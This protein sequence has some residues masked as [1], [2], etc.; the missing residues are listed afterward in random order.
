MNVSS[1][2]QYQ[3]PNDMNA[4][5][6]TARKGGEN[7]EYNVDITEEEFRRALNKTKKTTPGMDSIT[8][9]ILELL[10]NKIQ[11]ELL[12]IYN[13]SFGAAAAPEIW[14]T[15]L[16]LPILKPAKP[17]QEIKSY[18]PISLLSCSGKV[19]ERIIG[20]RLEY[21]AEKN[22]LLKPYQFGFRK[23]KSTIDVLTCVEH[24]IRSS[25]NAGKTCLV[26]YIDLESAFDKVW[27]RGLIYKLTK[28]NIKGRMLSWLDAYLTERTFLVEVGGKH[29]DKTPT[30]G[31]VPQG[32]AI[33]P[34]LFNLM[35]TD[36]PQTE[37]THIY[38]FADDITIISS[39]FRPEI[40]KRD[41]EAY[42]ELF[43]D[44]AEKWSIVINPG[45]TYL[46]VFGRRKYPNMPVRI[47]NHLLKQKSEQRLLG[48]ILDA[49]FLTW[50]PHVKYL[51]ANCSERN[52]LMKSITSTNWGACTKVLRA[53]YIAYIRSKLDYG[54]TLYAGAPEVNLRKLEVTQNNSLRL[55]LGARKTSPIL[56]LRAESGIP[57]LSF[58]RKFLTIKM[59]IK[60]RYQTEDSLVKGLV[61]DCA[62]G[63][64]PFN[65]F[66]YRAKLDTHSISFAITKAEP[67]TDYPII[68]P[69][70]N[71]AQIVI[72]ST[73]EQITQDEEL[74]AEI[75]NYPNFRSLFVDGSRIT[76]PCIST[77]SAVYI[78]HQNITLKYRLR[79][80]ATVFHSELYA[81]KKALD[82]IKN[83]NNNQDYI[84]FSDCKSALS[85]ICSSIN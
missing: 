64:P 84:I 41:L 45:K 38:A 3:I 39:N 43:M 51:I 40:A 57:S 58:R 53:F 23:G 59:R 76:R 50:I 16:I 81:I 31:G 22:Q 71:L 79:P 32:A 18:R 35:L 2:S 12:N 25:C 10:P 72:L 48:L 56:S 30:E 29:S 42:L 80:E 28:M 52:D 47:R 37:G 60:L 68:A 85:C 36:I 74:E 34:L 14:R 33:S 75:N 69:W 17:K 15:S 62:D 27:R 54:S 83:E 66:R 8:Y 49:P 1:L 21:V 78:P 5:I 55:M 70:I 61:G 4:A 19:L 67:F 20:S 82:Y 6:I 65:S 9:E 26:A 73:D 13:Q 77:G 63:L 7:E 11:E 24:H 46:Q 44:W